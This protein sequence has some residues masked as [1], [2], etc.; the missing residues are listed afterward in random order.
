MCSPLQAEEDEELDSFVVDNSFVE[1][2]TE[3]VWD[4]MLAEDPI[5]QHVGASKAC[6]GGFMLL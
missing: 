1:Y 2:E 3:H 6:L 5:I 4:T